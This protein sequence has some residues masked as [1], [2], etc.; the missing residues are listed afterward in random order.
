[1]RTLVAALLLIALA[2]PAGAAALGPGS[3]DASFGTNGTA[4]TRLGPLV[5]PGNSVTAARDVADVPGA[6]TLV[7]GSA[8]DADGA[9]A[10]AV[11]RYRKNG[12][13]DRSF[14]DKGVVVDQIGL[15]DEPSSA[16]TAILARPDGGAV[17]A[18]NATA[19]N[20]R[21]VLMVA[22]YSAAG[23]R[24]WTATP[25]IDGTSDAAALELLADATGRLLVVGRSGQDPFVGRFD[26]ETGL[27]DPTFADR[28]YVVDPVDRDP[29]GS[30]CTSGDAHATS[31]LEA[32]D[33]AVI[34]G[35]TVSRS[36]PGDAARP[37]ALMRRYT[38]LG[39]RDAD[40]GSGDL[41][42]DRITALT[43]APFSTGVV[44]TGTIIDSGTTVP[45]IA[46][47]VDGRVDGDFPGPTGFGPLPG[48]GQQAG[49]ATA[50]ATTDSTGLLV[51]GVDADDP[52]KADRIV[53]TDAGGQRDE[54]FVAGGLAAA[55]LFSPRAI[56]VQADGRIVVVGDHPPASAREAQGFALTRLFG[57]DAVSNVR[58]RGSAR[59]RKGALRL[60]LS[61]SSGPGCVGVVRGKRLGAADYA[62][63]GGRSAKLDVPV[64]EQ[65]RKRAALDVK[66][67]NPPS[68]A[69]RLTISVSR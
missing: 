43:R 21:T 25:M 7:A 53:R 35:G 41:G 57:S 15:G 9:R 10:A 1:M 54:T 69:L 28:G 65:A 37:R 17:I 4:F 20:G 32:A 26:V 39:V 66:V 33:G 38:G 42:L 51:L 50:I 67:T 48:F 19:S 60:R 56:S 46:R 22:R 14:A 23:R 6:G 63:K 8:P 68:A 30:G 31:V 44:A 55:A 2:L 59:V 45:A 5:E 40:F 64:L 36:C 3:L 24:L 47:I 52:A 13:L 16:A 49:M 18:G 12:R 34:V 61:C 62:I 11:V 58:V 29:D 27:L